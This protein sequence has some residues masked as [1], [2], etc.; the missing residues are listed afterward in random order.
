MDN[1][2][3]QFLK[4]LKEFIKSMV[5]SLVFVIVLTQFIARPVRVEGLSM[6]P[7][8]N[9]KEIGFSNIIS[10]KIT[11]VKRF[12]VVV[13]YLKEQNKYIVKRVIGLPGEE[14]MYQDEI[15]YIDDVIV[16]EPFL[17][18]SFREQFI[19]ED[20]EFM[21]DISPVK[22]GDDEYFLLG[23]NRPNSI[24]SRMYGLFKKDMIKSKGI[25]VILP[26]SR[27]RRVGRPR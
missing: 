10:T 24:D 19:K 12:D 25:F 13:V 17:E 5:I 21:Q 1:K 6:Y 15:L 16:N 11:K 2:D 7:S 3:D 8:L 27:I 14:I 4:V 20:R 18:N 22:I 26:L 9:D 23:D